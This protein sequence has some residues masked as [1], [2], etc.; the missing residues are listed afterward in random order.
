MK[1]FLIGTI[2][3]IS[4]FCNT[5]AQQIVRGPYLQMGTSNS[6]IVKWR[7]DVASTGKV[8]FGLSTTQ[9]SSSIS[10]VSLTTEHELKL[11]NLQANTVYFYNVG[12]AST[13]LQGNQDNY[14]KTA[15]VVGS[16]QK[17]RFWAMGDMGDGSANQVNVRDKYL[18]Y[19]GNDNKNTD[20]V[21]LLGDNAYPNGFDNEFQTNFF[22][23]YQPHFLK[24]NVLWA[25][26]GNHDYY[27]G[28]QTDRSLPYY[29]IFT[30]PQ[31][32]EA[33]GVA[34]GQE[35]YYSFDYANVHVVALDSYGIENN[36]YRLS[37]TLSPQVAWLKRDLAA[38]RQPWTIVMFHHPPYT[39]NSHDSDAELE[40]ALIRKF[41]NPILERFKVDLVLN[42]H[43][44]IYERTKLIKGHYGFSD[45][46]S[47]AL[48]AVSTS[49]GRYDGSANSC[50]YIN[51][52]DGTIYALVGSSGRNNG[53]VGTWHPAMAYTN[54]LD[55]GSLAIEIENN[56][57]D[58]KWINSSGIIKDQ[59][60]VFKNVNKK[61]ALTPD[62][63][64]TVRLNPSWK[65]T[66]NWTNNTK[67]AFL[68]WV[69]LKDTVISVK[70]DQN[71][72]TD[73]F[74]LRVVNTPRVTTTF[75]PSTATCAGTT[76][77]VGF[78][79]TGINAAARSFTLQLSDALGNFTAPTVLATS[80]T[81][82]ISATIPAQFA[83]GNAYKMR[84]IADTISVNYV[85]SSPF[86]LYTKPTATLTGNATISVGDSTFLSIAFTGNSP[87][88]YTFTNTNSGTTSSNPLRGIVKPT[89][90][91]TYALASVSNVCGAGTVSGSAKVRVT[92][93]IS[94]TS[95][96]GTVCAGST[97][98]V[99]F[100]LTGTFDTTSVS[101]IAQLSDASGNFTN[102][103]NIGNGA[104]SP[105][106][107]TIPTNMA[108]GTNY[109]IRVT[110]SAPSTSVASPAF[111]IKPKPTAVLS[112]N[113]SINVGDSTFL[114][115]AFT[116]D[117]P[118]TY[119]I[120]N[121]TTG[122]T[123]TN[124]LKGYVKPTSTTTY[125]LSSVSNACGSGSVSGSAKI[126]VI[127]RISTANLNLGSICLGANASVPF[128]VAG[129]FEGAVSYTAQLSDASGNFTNPTTIGT[130]ASSPIAVTIPTAV[131]ASNG[132]KIRVTASASAT[133][134][135]SAIFVIK[136]LPTATISGSGSVNF[137]DAI[138]I[139][140]SFTGESPW[141]FK[142]S[143]GTTGTATTSPTTISIKPS[144]TS[145]ITVSSVQNVCGVGTSSG[146][147]NITVIPRLTTENFPPFVC[148]GDVIDVKF[149]I[150]GLLPT[151]TSY[152]VQLSDSIG[153]FTAPVVLGNGTTSPIS[154]TIPVST[155]SASK[156]RVRVIATN[157]S[158]I[159]VL[160]SNTFIVR[161][162]A[163]ATLSGGGVA[164]KPGE[165]AILVIQ[166]GGDGPWTYTLSDNV[167]TATTSTSPAVFS[168]FPQYPTTY[169]IKALSNA[170][171]AGTAT[172][173]AVVNVIITS[174][175]NNLKDEVRVF[176]NPAQEQLN[177]DIMTST[178]QDG[179][180]QLFNQNGQ[181]LKTNAWKK[182]TEFRENILLQNYSSGIYFLKVRV[183]DAWT[184]RKIEK[185]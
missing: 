53:V 70:D 56:R 121:G 96:L 91:T 180:W 24:N 65:G 117:A 123:S 62:F 138:A 5:N 140:L 100:V 2:L 148:S 175:D 166:F 26:P 12:T 165:E 59:F 68:D 19:I 137:G 16:T 119:S 54:Q 33:G 158:N 147:A 99:P 182:N 10:D 43:S 52:T 136:P 97:A 80:R 141:A 181:Q 179:D 23:V 38:N 131:S 163:T 124:P 32:A 76:V 160:P 154:C 20:L 107:I 98:S 49:S 128:E 22:D 14:F 172:G 4:I 30:L 144:Q 18:Q 63:G 44:H 115:I 143:E 183:G 151:N 162:K 55:G 21:L 41:L 35:A 116:G 11:S 42:G 178:P 153:N 7:T 169:T 112:G 170:C 74:S 48:Y 66:Y 127:P 177:L 126:T 13:I 81:S 73:Q 8:S 57:L 142:L 149:G 82:P 145:T 83:G 6:I 118:W 103:V 156:Y 45:T 86:A 67:G 77:S 46:Y 132:Y 39:K 58:A 51:K 102:P 28:L 106:A 60:T 133:S 120:T 105:I 29:Q 3:L 50:A 159:N 87:W 94:V 15:P 79:T 69:A 36:Q 25:I 150:G 174:V 161:R 157:T 90:T 92:P 37:D 171:G 93:R 146:G 184:V 31:N 185:D 155:L 164:I 167:T 109:K 122:T 104:S 111:V 78:T 27:A 75:T 130:G 110:S 114:S 176:P 88:T 95:G 101:Y 168:V 125:T 72:I 85:A 135:P 113:A 173:S 40:L 1:R 64:S 17:V 9:L 152:Q 89:V 134:Q 34:S 47:D 139:N 129:V 71:C 61:T 108:G 84:V